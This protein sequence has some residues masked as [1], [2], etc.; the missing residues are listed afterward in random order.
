MT[1]TTTDIKQAR[2]A[3]AAGQVIAYPTEAV[4]GL[5]CAAADQAAVQR[6]RQLKQ[7]AAGQ[8]VITLVKDLSQVSAWLDNN[9][10]ALWPKADHS[11]PAA[12]TWLFPASGQAPV[13]LTGGT[14]RIALRCPGHALARLL[15]EDMPIISTS[16][17]PTGQA[18][19]VSAAQVADYFNDKLDLIV[20]GE[21][22]SNA[23]PS[24]I[25]DLVSDKILR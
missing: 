7:R 22:G 4:Y 24:E 11:W 13:W 1:V 6:V 9:Y 8:G 12:I 3:L 2:V 23:Q 14:D 5:G 19:A 21:C 15:C 10:A 20:A 16:A 25:R 17:N 18:P